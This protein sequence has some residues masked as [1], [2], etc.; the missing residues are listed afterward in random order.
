M[1]D[2]TLVKT[3]TTLAAVVTGCLVYKFFPA[4]PD[5]VNTALRDSLLAASAAALGAVHIG[6]PGD[7]KLSDVQVPPANEVKPL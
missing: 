7:V 6:R 1:I 3:L 4:S 5:W 2:P